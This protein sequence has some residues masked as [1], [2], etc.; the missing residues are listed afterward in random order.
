[1]AAVSLAV[2]LASHGYSTVEPYTDRN[3]ARS[4]RPICEGPSW[5]METPAC[6]PLTQIPA[7]LMEAMRTKS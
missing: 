7:P 3:I 6:E 5:P 2:W 1:M 4:S